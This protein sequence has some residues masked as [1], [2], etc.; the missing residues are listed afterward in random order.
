MTQDTIL[1]SFPVSSSSSLLGKITSVGLWHGRWRRKEGILSSLYVN[2][3][4]LSLEYKGYGMPCCQSVVLIL[5]RRTKYSWEIKGKQECHCSQCSSCCVTRRNT[6]HHVLLELHV[7]PTATV[8]T[9]FSLQLT[10]ALNNLSESKKVLSVS[11]SCYLSKD[12]SC[13]TISCFTLNSQFNLKKYKYRSSNTREK[14]GRKIVP[15]RTGRP[16]W[17]VTCI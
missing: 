17:V 3:T 4:T 8:A 11:E 7:A 2:T 13:L 9:T 10:L 12:F 14:V 6:S 1:V 5:P 15:G 16:L